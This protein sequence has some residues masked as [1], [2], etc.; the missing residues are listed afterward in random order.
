MTR[1]KL[2]VILVLA[3]FCIVVVLQNTQAVET[4]ILFVT[5]TMPRAILL[6]LASLVGFVAG[7]I[8]ALGLSRRKK[9]GAKKTD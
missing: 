7:I 2:I 6:F 8:L 3:I 5:I 9:T 1:T 4:R